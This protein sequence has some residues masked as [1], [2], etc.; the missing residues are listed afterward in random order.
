[1]NVWRVIH[2]DKKR[3]RQL[4]SSI[5]S[6]T[7]NRLW[8]QRWRFCANMECQFCKVNFVFLA[9][10]FKLAFQ[11]ILHNLMLDSWFVNVRHGSSHILVL[12]L[13]V[14]STGLQFGIDDQRFH[15]NSL[16]IVNFCLSHSGSFFQYQ[17]QMIET[18]FIL[19]CVFFG[20][21]PLSFCSGKCNSNSDH[22]CTLMS[23]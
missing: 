23:Q 12:N 18:N 8:P 5:C 22:N 15:H 20:F 7:I 16:M 2:L 11:Y 1:M 21:K 10:V 6:K 3:C 19:H 13:E 9:V 17:H 14:Y 4:V